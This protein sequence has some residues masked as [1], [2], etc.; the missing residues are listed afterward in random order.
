M[1][2]RVKT[3]KIYNELLY[4]RRTSTGYIIFDVNIGNL[5]VKKKKQTSF[6]KRIALVVIEN[7]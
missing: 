5:T 6:I 1:F 2:G 7:A 3:A 4:F